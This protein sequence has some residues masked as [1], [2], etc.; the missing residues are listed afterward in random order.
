MKRVTEVLHLNGIAPGVCASTSEL[1]V[2][3][4]TD[5]KKCGA[6]GSGLGSPRIRPRH[7]GGSLAERIQH[8]WRAYWE[9]RA[10]QAV[11]LLLR[12][13]DDRALE[14]LGLTPDDIARAI[15]E[16]D[17]PARHRWRLADADSRIGFLRPPRRSLWKSR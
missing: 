8:I 5:N 17:G 6:P 13:L 12:S 15:G 11:V 7:L 1:G 9:W 4:M 16:F 10:R 2:P 3:S 14:D